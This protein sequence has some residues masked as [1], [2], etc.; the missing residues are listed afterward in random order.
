MNDAAA[1]LVEHGGDR[2]FRRSLRRQI[3]LPVPAVPVLLAAGALAGAGKMSWRCRLPVAR[4]LPCRRSDLV[5]GGPPSWPARAESVV[6]H[7]ARA[8]FLRAPD[9][10]FFER[11]GSFA[12]PRQVR[13]RPQHDHAG[14]GRSI[15]RE[16]AGSFFC[17]TTAGALV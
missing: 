9:E 3:G 8:G 10:N 12:D 2:P 17:S 11:H 6:P 4:R 5:R 13:S 7:L 15:W 1:F 14:I 16:R